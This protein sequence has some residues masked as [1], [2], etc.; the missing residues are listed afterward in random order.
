MPTRKFATFTVT[1][2]GQRQTVRLTKT[3]AV[4]L[5]QKARQYGYSNRGHDRVANATAVE[6]R[7]PLCSEP[8]TGYS[9]RG[10]TVSAAL[11]R[12]VLEHFVDCSEVEQP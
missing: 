10:V 4:R 1:T 9:G 6:V 2:A 12:A 8:V 11:D 3:V 5:A 7:C